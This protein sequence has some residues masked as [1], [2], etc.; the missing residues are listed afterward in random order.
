MLWVLAS[1]V[2]RG[3]GHEESGGAW[4]CTKENLRLRKRVLEER[5]QKSALGNQEG[6]LG[7]PEDRATTWGFTPELLAA[8]ALSS[9]IFILPVFPSSQKFKKQQEVNSDL[10]GR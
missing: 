9:G 6:A 3:L 2:F 4:E 10:K 8:K 1:V 5:T 7:G